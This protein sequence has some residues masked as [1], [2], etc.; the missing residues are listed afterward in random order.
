MRRINNNLSKNLLVYICAFFVQFQ[1]IYAEAK[2]GFV[3]NEVIANFLK[4]NFS[5]KPD[6]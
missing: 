1:F 2:F 5:S 6:F 4:T 3:R